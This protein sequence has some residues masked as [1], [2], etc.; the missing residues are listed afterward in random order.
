M[1]EAP[2]DAPEAPAEAHSRAMALWRLSVTTPD[3]NEIANVAARA[4]A[5]LYAAGNSWGE[6]LGKFFSRFTDWKDK[7]AKGEMDLT[8]NELRHAA[9]KNTRA[10]EY[11]D[12]VIAFGKDP[13]A[14]DL[15]CIQSKDVREVIEEGQRR[16]TELGQEL[17]RNGWQ[18]PTEQ[19][20]P[21]AQPRPDQSNGFK[22]N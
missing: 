13:M 15:D 22:P 8:E 3:W 16:F 5:W 7:I 1:P 4:T 14:V 10:G 6:P 21:Q 20:K 18:P 11:Y 9:K 12:P 19:Q 17:V 2:H